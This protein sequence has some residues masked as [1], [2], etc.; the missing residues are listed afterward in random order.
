VILNR[1]IKTTYFVNHVGKL[2]ITKWKVGHNN[3]LTFKEVCEELS[4]LD[5]T[6]LLEVLDI[7]SNEIVN[8][9]QDKIEEDL[10]SLAIDLEKD[11]TLDL[12]NQDID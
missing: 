7:T 12:F 1:I 9:F 8:K 6:T 5:E 10:E 11:S 4:K 2:L 3:M